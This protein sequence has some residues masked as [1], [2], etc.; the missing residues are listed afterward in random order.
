M[1]WCCFSNQNTAY[2]VRIS[3]WSSDVCSS[4]LR[5]RDPDRPFSVIGAPAMM[6]P[7]HRRKVGKRDGGECQTSEHAILRAMG[8]LR[9]DPASIS[10]ERS[11]RPISSQCM[12]VRRQSQKAGGHH[13]VSLALIEQLLKEGFLPLA[14]SL[15]PR[16][17]ASGAIAAIVIGDRKS[18]RL[19]SSH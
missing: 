16:L 8:S 4:D 12:P 10:L 15:A 1:M 18:T 13:P 2:Y 6:R 9:M 19:N 7:C 11:N 14:V 3:D 17:S 5:Q